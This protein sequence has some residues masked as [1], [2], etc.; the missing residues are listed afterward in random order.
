MFD[1]GLTSE[2]AFDILLGMARTRVR[3]GRVAV[4]A[5]LVVLAVAFF[6]AR[7]GARSAVLR[8]QPA[9][10]VV[11]DG[12]TLW[13]IAVSIAGPREDPRPVVDELIRVNGLGTATILEGQRLVLPS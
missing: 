2:H 12:E 6:G 5:V 3:W 11:A 10:H 9:T 4:L 8:P 7:A 1:S 13:S